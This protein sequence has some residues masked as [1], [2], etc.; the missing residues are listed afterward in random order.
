MKQNSNLNVIETEPVSAAFTPAGARTVPD[1]IRAALRRKLRP[2]LDEIIGF[3]KLL[4]AQTE[5]TN[6]VDCTQQIVSAAKKLLAFLETELGDP[7]EQTSNTGSRAIAAEPAEVLYI[8]DDPANVALVQ[9]TLERRPALHLRHAGTGEAGLELARHRTP[10]LILLDLD[11][12][13]I[14]GA[15]VLRRLQQDASTAHIPVVVISA[16]ATPSRIERLLAA[17]ARDYLTKPFDIKNFLGVVDQII[18]EQSA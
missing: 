16:D 13:D 5:A 8:E 3:A 7:V 9:R 18:E 10:R 11:L 4:A 1:E 2:P 15:E 17:G 6:Q 14:N 12:P